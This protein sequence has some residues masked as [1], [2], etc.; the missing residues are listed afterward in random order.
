LRNHTEF[1]FLA[2]TGYPLQMHCRD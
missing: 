1:L 2:E